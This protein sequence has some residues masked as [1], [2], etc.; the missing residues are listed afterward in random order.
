M[1]TLAHLTLLAW[2]GPQ[3]RAYL[4]RMAR[5]GLRPARLILM[6]SPRLA[7]V[8]NALSRMPVAA[9]IGKFCLRVAEGTQDSSNNFHP[10][11]LL[12]QH[13]ELIDSIAIGMASHVED[14]RSLWR[15]MYERSNRPN[16]ANRA[17]ETR[18]TWMWQG[19][20]RRC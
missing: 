6:V 9:P 17:E 4:V 19:G 2:E 20:M 13:P 16:A 8:G 14:C 5:A 1:K 11:K 10:Y 3:A 18:C 15:E 7:R 12:K